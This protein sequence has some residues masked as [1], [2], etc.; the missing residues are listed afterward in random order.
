MHDV[1]SFRQTQA[2]SENQKSILLKDMRD[3]V[4]SVV[5]LSILR[6]FS[7]EVIKVFFEGE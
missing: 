2:T 4:N 7:G 1:P 3:T 6:H 5:V